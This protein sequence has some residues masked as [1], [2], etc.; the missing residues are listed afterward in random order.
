M[1]YRRKSGVNGA[2]QVEEIAEDPE[3]EAKEE[4]PTGELIDGAWL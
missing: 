3:E 4:A 1:T 2:N